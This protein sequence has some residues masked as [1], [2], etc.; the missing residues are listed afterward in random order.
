MIS[1][2]LER[3]QQIKFFTSLN[4]FTVGIPLGPNEEVTD[5]MAPRLPIK[6][7]YLPILRAVLWGVGFLI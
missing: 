2:R 7:T 1:I 5:L 4:G 6:E 3:L